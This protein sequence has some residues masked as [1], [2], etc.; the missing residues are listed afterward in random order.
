MSRADQCDGALDVAGP[1][2]LD[3]T[4]H[5]H[6]W[7]WSSNRTTVLLSARSYNTLVPSDE[8]LERFRLLL[9]KFERT[10]AILK[11]ARLFLTLHWP[12]YPGEYSTGDI[13]QLTFHSRMQQPQVAVYFPVDPILSTGYTPAHVT[14]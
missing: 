6:M 12:P 14:A 13:R 8:I 7:T 10:K 4:C 9:R 2:D 11:G 3:G 1:V 5:C